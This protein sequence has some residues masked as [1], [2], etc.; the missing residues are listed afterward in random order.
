MSLPEESPGQTPTPV[1]PPRP[2]GRRLSRLAWRVGLT[3]LEGVGALVGLVLLAV[4]LLA[5]RL[6][7]GPLEVDWLTPVLVGVVESRAAPLSVAIGR[8]SLGWTPGRPTIELIAGDLRLTDAVRGQLLALPQLAVSFS[9]KELVLHGRLAPTRVTLIG[10]RLRIVRAR[11]GQVDVGLVQPAP[12]AGEPATRPLAAVLGDLSGAPGAEGPLGLLGEFAV[13]R[14]DATVEDQRIGLSWRLTG[15]AA[16]LRRSPSGFD[17]A[18][19]GQVGLGGAETRSEG[20]V[21]FDAPSGRLHF[22][23]RLDGLDP[24]RAGAALPPLLA[25]AA[26]AQLPIGLALEGSFDAGRMR[27][28]A[29]AVS[30]RTGAGALVDPRLPDGR[31]A[32]RRIA[33]DARYDAGVGRLDLAGLKIDLGGPTLELQGLALGV[34]PAL[35]R[36]VTVLGRAELHGLPIDRLG[37]LWPPGLARD[38]RSWVTEH[39]STGTVASGAAQAIVSVD[40]GAAPALLPVAY[41]GTLAVENAT[42]DY[43]PGL[44]KVEGVDA[45]MAMAP[46]RLAFAVTAG[47]LRGLTVPQGTIVIDE[48]DAPFERMTI[49]VGVRGPA[50]DVL[51]VLDAKRLQYAKAMGLV[52][53]AVGGTVDGLLHFRFRLKKELPFSEIEYDAQ[54]QLAGLALPDIA[55][56]RDLSDGAFKLALDASRVSLDGSAKLDGVPATV[57]WMQRLTGTAGP[58][59]RVH[60]TARLDDQAR[61]RFGLD[62]IPDILEGT[63]G[64]EVTYTV[65]DAHHAAAE[66]V[67]DL[68]DA[69]LTVEQA[70]WRKA[71]GPPARASFTVGLEDGHVVRLDRLEARAPELDLSG[72]LALRDG[73][74]VRAEIAQLRLG[75]T[76]LDGTVLH[77]GDA[78]WQATLRG[79]TVDL[80]TFIKQ[81]SADRHAP[82]KGTGPSIALDLAADRVIVGPK[83]ELRAVAL[84]AA[85]ARHALA[86]GKLSASLGQAGKLTAWLDPVEAGGHFRLATDDFGALFQVAGIADNLV[87]GSLTITGESK[88]EGPARRFSGRIEG[89]DYKLLRMPFLTRLLSLASF[90][91]AASLMAGTGIPFTTLKADF[92]LKQGRLDI[93]HGRA[94]GGAIGLNADGW[95]DL[96]GKTL[97]FDATLV[98]A[99]YLNSA[100]GGL[101]VLGELLLGG[102]GQG[103]FGANVRLSGTLAEPSIAVNPLSALAPG[104]LRNLFLFDAPGSGEQPAAPDN[105]PP[106]R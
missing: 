54:A 86:S 4:I 85:I 59:S 82:E 18:F 106:P 57:S 66:T 100:L 63:V 69:A 70:G 97:G 78:P 71:P 12:E 64:A 93:H 50:S 21:R 87:G 1:P 60:A 45:T 3:V 10:P 28:E 104:F 92:S 46:D 58:L 103:V 90:Q 22:N 105:P 56:G 26:A 6:Q 101:P 99:Y 30:G 42:V 73:N 17:A 48:F 81:L 76:E 61:Q 39:L 94:Y 40:P 67:L 38:A 15:G 51:T 32:V 9:S 53:A 5:L 13:E 74:V 37:A 65:A 35:S 2:R 62:P 8:T 7:W 96:D 83:R 31:L 52:P 79:R 33:L 11:D 43:L 24:S 84:D 44:E 89:T 25:P 98:P 16:T 27:F 68:A 55:F 77:E 14:A 36:R 88:Q 95:F 29:L 72:R 49:D 20:L 91:S 34:D 19:V 41:S 23:L 75:Q 80:T 47:R 102:E